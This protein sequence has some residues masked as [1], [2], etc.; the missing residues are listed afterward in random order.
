MIGALG[1]RASACVL[2]FGGSFDPP[3]VAHRDLPECARAAIG[4]DVLVYCPAARSPHKPRGP[5]ASDTDRV[6]M[7][8]ALLAGSPH[9]TIATLEIDRAG[10]GEAS[11]TVDTL[12]TARSL[13]PDHAELRLLIGEDQARA[14]ERWREPAR[15]VALAEPVVMVRASADEPRG[16]WERRADRLAADLGEAWRGRVVRTPSSPASSTRAR[17][18]L[19]RPPSAERDA[20]LG[21]V[22][23]PGVREIIAG[24]SLYA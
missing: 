23:T 21:G 15:I 9:A 3:T 6:D 5:V 14:F 16:D 19:A 13:L 24:R 7:L 11:Y 10:A 1:E 4:A 18:L 22:L 12:A 17:E 20:E 8:R 2:W